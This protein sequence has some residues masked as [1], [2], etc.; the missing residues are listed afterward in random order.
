MATVT[1]FTAARMLEI[2]DAAIVSG[3]V[4]SNGDLILTTHGGSQINAGYVIGPKGDTGSALD[5]WP[6][7]SIYLSISDSNPATIFGGGTWVRFAEGRV[8]I[9]VDSGQTEFDTVE[10]TGGEKTHI[11]STGELPNHY[12]QINHDHASVT[13]GGGAHSHTFPV[14][15]NQTSPTSGT[16]YHVT[17]VGGIPVPA[18]GT[19]EDGVTNDDSPA[20]THN[21]DLPSYSGNS[22][23]YGD[24]TAHNNLQPY[25]T[26]Y[27]WKRTA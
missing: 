14:R 13:S 2:E 26:C 17:K 5:A 18:G 3:D 8:I 24:G 27:I 20:H 22:G 25:I 1:G 12:H 7:G 21:V 11:L 4:D 15:W 16:A 9:G 10:E 19:L 23:A 6:V